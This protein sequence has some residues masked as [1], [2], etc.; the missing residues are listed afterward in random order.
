MSKKIQVIELKEI[1]F[2]EREVEGNTEFVEVFKNKKKY[3][4]YLSNAALKKGRDEGLIDGSLISDVIKLDAET[5][6]ITDEKEKGMKM[7]DSLPEHKLHALI[8]LA[9]KGANRQESFSLDE[10]L[11]RYHYSHLETVRMYTSLI[12]DTMQQNQNA[13]ADG[14]KKSTQGAKSGEKK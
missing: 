4:L 11:E 13:F 2:E 7:L 5:K 14:L 1:E 3:P 9:F 12:K 8:Y 6:H 10:F